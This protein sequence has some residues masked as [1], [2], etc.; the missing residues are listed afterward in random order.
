MNVTEEHILPKQDITLL[1]RAARKGARMLDSHHPRR[2]QW[3]HDVPILSLDIGSGT[4]CVMGNVAAKYCTRS[5]DGGMISWI[6]GLDFIGMTEAI[7]AK[8]SDFTGEH[9][10]VLP[11]TIFNRIDINLRPWWFSNAANEALTEAW[12]DE[13]RARRKGYKDARD[14]TLALAALAA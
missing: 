12:R 9:G 13:I 14:M 1:K 7:R 8:G 11:D 10:F 3:A 5:E 6:D 2:R 4:A